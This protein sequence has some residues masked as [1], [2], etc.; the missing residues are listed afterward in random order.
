MIVRGKREFKT[1]GRDSNILPLRRSAII[2]FLPYG[3]FGELSYMVKKYPANSC[4]VFYK[5]YSMLPLFF[6]HPLHTI[7]LK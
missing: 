4:G 7:T 1:E 3:K 6:F 2:I 5:Q